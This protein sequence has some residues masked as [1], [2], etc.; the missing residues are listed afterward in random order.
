MTRSLPQTRPST[1]ILLVVALLLVAARPAG[2]NMIFN[3]DFELGNVGFTSDYSTPGLLDQGWYQ[4]LTDVPV[5]EAPGRSDRRHGLRVHRLWTQPAPP[6]GP[7]WST[8]TGS[9]RASEAR[10][11]SAGSSKL[12]AAS[13]RRCGLTLVETSQDGLDPIAGTL[14]PSSHTGAPMKHSKR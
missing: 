4:V 9:S 8:R 6:A 10:D 3:G 7:C 1:R 14:G 13:R 12:S 2:A 5:H 11:R